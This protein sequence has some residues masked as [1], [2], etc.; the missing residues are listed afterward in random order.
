MDANDTIRDPPR[1]EAPGRSKTLVWVMLVIAGLIALTTAIGTATG[2]VASDQRLAESQISDP[3]LHGAQREAEVKAMVE[4][5]QR[6][7]PWTLGTG[8]PY[9]IATAFVCIFGIAVVRG[10]SNRWRR[11]LMAAALAAAVA[12]I[13]VGMVTYDLTVDAVD[14]MGKVIADQQ[15]GPPGPHDDRSMRKA[16]EMTTDIATTMTTLTSVVV[17]LFWLISGLAVAPAKKDE[18]EPAA[19]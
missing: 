8:I 17:A 1:A 11:R 4:M 9:A 2:M 16:V 10:D 5:S 19:S 12:R 14:V 7:K 15:R 18:D 13:A 6:W 3:N